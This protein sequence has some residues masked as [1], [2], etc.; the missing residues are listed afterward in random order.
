MKVHLRLRAFTLCGIYLHE[1]LDRWKTEQAVLPHKAHL[2]EGDNEFET[3]NT[4]VDNWKK[5]QEEVR[6]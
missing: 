4:C 6:E 1:D 5:R 2:L 3:C